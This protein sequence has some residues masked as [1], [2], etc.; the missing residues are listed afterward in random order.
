MTQD[1]NDDLRTRSENDNEQRNTAQTMVDSEGIRPVPSLKMEPGMMV[2]GFR[3]IRLLGKGAMGEVWLAHQVSMDREVALKILPPHLAGDRNYLNRF[4]RE[5]RLAAKLDHPNIVTAHEAGEAGGFLYLAMTYVKGETITDRLKQEGRIKEPEALRIIQQMAQ[6]LDYAWSDHKLLHRD[7]KPS[8][9]MLDSRGQA[10]LMDLGISK[11]MQDG[12]DMTMTE[13]VVGT[14]NY[15]SPEQVEGRTDLDF[16]SDL[17]S[18][19]MTLYQMLTG[20]VPFRGSSVIETLRKQ[21]VENLPSVHEYNPGVSQNC[22]NLLETMLAKSRDKRH[23]SWAAFIADLDRV[24]TDGNLPDPGLKEGESAMMRLNRSDRSSIQASAQTQ[25][26]RNLPA[27]A[28]DRKPKQA[29][30]KSPAR[31]GKPSATARR[32][33]NFAKSVAW[34]VVVVAVGW[35]LIQWARTTGFGHELEKLM[36]TLAGRTAEETS[37][38]IKNLNHELSALPQTVPIAPGSAPTPAPEDQNASGTLRTL[39]P[40]LTEQQRF[41]AALTELRKHVPGLNADLRP[42]NGTWSLILAGNATLSSIEPLAG[43][44]LADLDISKTAVDS[45]AMLR[46]VPLRSLDASDTR[47]SDIA[48]LSSLPLEQLNIS[49]TAVTDFSPLAS[50]HSL[51]ALIIKQ[52]TF[53]DKDLAQL[54]NLNAIHSLALSGTQITRLDILAGLPLQMLYVADCP[55]QDFR[56]LLSLK[57]LKD[58]EIGGQ[59][60]G[61]LN[62]LPECCPRL[63]MLRI[64]NAVK[65]PI[66]GG[67]LRRFPALQIV[68]IG[69]QR[70]TLEE[71]VQRFP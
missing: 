41:D 57:E 19:G 71:A 65:T 55:I 22:V 17:Y 10:K 45:L 53:G 13:T 2:A 60:Y 5:V 70:L 4:L 30:A 9:I 69:D 67:W 68:I 3:V 52:L 20:K 32:A 56:P 39:I 61:T 46:G 11:C 23:S 58:L 14:P 54:A 40:P 59:S 49:H 24:L 34:L 63:R 36:S 50:I 25:P 31:S 26:D 47:V 48:P 21:V 43:L 15:M 51:R 27:D 18:L 37:T 12:M 6:A 62:R 16:R 33:G 35:L 66:T 42:G 38:V 29:A 8:N 64:P 44:P 7:I 1:P 28:P